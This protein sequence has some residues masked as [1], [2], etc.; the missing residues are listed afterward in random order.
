MQIQKS[1]PAAY[2]QHLGTLNKGN[3]D[4][5]YKNRFLWWE[6]HFFDKFCAENKMGTIS[7][8]KV[9]CHGQ[10]LGYKEILSHIKSIGGPNSQ[11]SSNAES[12]ELLTSSCTS[13]K[14]D[15]AGLP[16]EGQEFPSL[17]I[18]VSGSCVCP[19]PTKNKEIWCH[20]NS[21]QAMSLL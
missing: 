14:I 7:T 16:G 10:E 13:I 20:L 11:N 18:S 17:G 8:G 2:V 15:Q 6:F 21:K 5:L 19:F 9:P 12:L 1:R 3:M 4:L